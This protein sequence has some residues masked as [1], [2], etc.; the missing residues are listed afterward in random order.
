MPGVDLANFTA[1]LGEEVLTEHRTAD[2][3]L[4]SQIISPPKFHSASYEGTL[5]QGGRH[6]LVRALRIVLSSAEHIFVRLG[7]FIK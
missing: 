1:W 5:K 7:V 2:M 4:P 6:F 3:T